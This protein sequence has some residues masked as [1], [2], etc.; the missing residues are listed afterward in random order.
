M[1]ITSSYNISREIWEIDWFIVSL[2]PSNSGITA[3]MDGITRLP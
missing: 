2:F 1:V 3:K